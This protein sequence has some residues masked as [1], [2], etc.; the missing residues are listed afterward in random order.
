MLG[1]FA[2]VVP[3]RGEEVALDLVPA[4]ARPIRG[5][6]AAERH[7]RQ[8]QVAK[9]RQ[10]RGGGR[11]GERAGD[12]A[13]RTLAARRGA[14]GLLRLPA[15]DGALHLPHRRRRD[16]LPPSSTS[17]LATSRGSEQ[18]E[19]SGAHRVG[20]LSRPTRSS[21]LPRRISLRPSRRQLEVLP[22]RSLD[23]VQHPESL[24]NDDKRWAT[25]TR[26]CLTPRGSSGVEVKGAARRGPV[27]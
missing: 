27:R 24:D 15:R 11:A 12:E 14:R 8:R 26:H 1:R 16:R 25:M 13:R 3:V 17:S 19:A 22:S 23:R 7:L 18:S 10:Q 6:A 21:R 4:A 5:R 2:G 20:A 9:R